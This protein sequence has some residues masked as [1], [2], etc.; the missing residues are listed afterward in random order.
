MKVNVMYAR[1]VNL[2]AP[3]EYVPV[4]KTDAALDE[5]PLGSLIKQYERAFPTS[6]ANA[7]LHALR[8]SEIIVRT[9]PLCSAS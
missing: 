5:L 9:V 4:E 3:T 2:I 7:S 1:E 6:S 8:P